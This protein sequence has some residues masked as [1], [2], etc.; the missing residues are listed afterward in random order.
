M[1]DIRE[2]PELALILNKAIQIAKESKHSYIT[3][4]HFL[5]AMILYEPMTKC[6]ESFGVDADS[7]ASELKNYLLSRQSLAQNTTSS[8]TPRKTETFSRIINRAV[9]QVLINNKDMVQPLDIFIKILQETNSFASFAIQKHGITFDNIN[10]FVNHYVENY[11]PGNATRAE[12]LSDEYADKILEKYCTNLTAEA[13]AKRIDPVIDREE[14]LDTIAKVFA[15][16]K[17]SSVLMVGDTGVG[18]TAIAEGLARR[19]VKGNVPEYLQDWEVYSLDVGTLV[20]GSKYRGQFEEKVRDVID[21][22]LKKGKAILFIDEAHQI[23]G[24]GAGGS[25]EGVDLSNMLK[26]ALAR[27]DLKFL[28]STTWEELSK[29]FEKD[30]ALM[31]RVHILTID[32]PSVESSKEILH[33]VKKYFEQHH[34]G[35]ISDNAINSAVDL[36]HRYQTDKRL[37]DKAIDLIDTACAQKR[38]EGQADWEITD[39]DIMIE[40]SKITKIPLD[41]FTAEKSERITNVRGDILDRL[42][43][44]DEV[45]DEV[46]DS[47]YQAKAGLKENDKPIGSYIFAGPTGVGKTELC[48]NLA[49]F[50]DM[51]LL[52][53]NLSEYMEKHSVAR[54]IGAPP[55]YVGYDDSNLQGGLLISDVTKNPNSLVLFD[56]VEK[57]HPDVLNILL[58]IMD[59]ARATGSNGKDANFSNCLIVMTTN[60][61]AEEN[62]KDLP[63]F[64][65]NDESRDADDKA[66]KELLRPEFRNRVD[67]ICKFKSLDKEIMPKIV[68]KFIR[69]LNELTQDRNITV[70]IDQKMMDQ[71]IERGFDKQMGARPLKRVIKELVKVP[72]SKKLLFDNVPNY[73]RIIVGWEKDEPTFEIIKNLDFDDSDQGII[74][75]QQEKLEE[76]REEA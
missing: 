61:G 56:E 50:L 6:I 62:E 46:L 76:Y 9:A 72:L 35:L 38:L 75:E 67:G 33:G 3:T 51:P 24:A 18:K 71:L 26:P 21:S 60:A 64:M 20:A 34:E 31:R 70:R 36:S 49:E 25:N 44:Q 30:K 68:N 17:K 73:S 63:G 74:N 37:P 4:E 39:L 11:V 65:R 66:L 28:A 53:Y 54:L 1:S 14:E 52:R 45:V 7:L 8:V 58:Q 29:S 57:A 23:K 47:V 69:E 15:K 22:L 32:E 12:N 59:E 27:G 16:R 55:G 5:L 42:Y 10:E 40:L 19:I 43:G 48:K 13:R 41:H 2:N